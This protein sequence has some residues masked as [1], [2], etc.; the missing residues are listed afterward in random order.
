M[1]TKKSYPPLS[2]LRA[3]YGKNKLIPQAYE[4][5]ILKTL[6]HFPE[7][8]DTRIR[9]VLHNRGEVPLETVASFGSMLVQGHRRSFTI[10]IL[11]EAELPVRQVLLKNLPEEAKPGAIGH[12]LGHVLRM[13]NSGNG[14]LME[15]KFTRRA[16]AKRKHERAADIATIEHGLG[17]ELYVYADYIRKV[18]GYIQHN[19][20][21]DTYY[22][23]PQEIL[24]T[25]P[26]GSVAP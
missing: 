22:L 13:I 15:H 2:E 6:S 4:E 19:K 12:E 21:I 17:F 25:L 24:D 5:V 16:L 18:P 14:A 7:L 10:M 9:F 20:E 26:E 8:I 11:E 23:K 1:A 3:R